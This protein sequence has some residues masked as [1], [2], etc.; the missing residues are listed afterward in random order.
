MKK[1]IILTTY[2]LLLI[3][4]LGK[5]Q[6]AINNSAANPDA[7]AILDLNT[8][9]AG[10][11]KGF[12]APQVALTNVTLAAPVTSPATGLIVY[13]TTA[14]IGGNGTG[15]YY[16]SGSAWLSLGTSPANANLTQGTG[17]T[18]FTYNGTGAATVGIA[19]TGV[20]ANSYG[21]T[22]TYPTFTVNAQGQLT[23]AG[24]QPLPTSLPPNGTAGGDL[25]GTYPNPTVAKINGATVPVAG[26][27]TTGNVLQVNGINSTTYGPVDIAGGA[28]YIT[29]N[30]P[31]TNLN[32]GTNASSTTFW[33]GDGTWANPT[34]ATLSNLTQGTGIT[35]FTYNGSS[36]ATVGLA[37]TGVTAGSYGSATT[38]PTYTVNAQGQITG[39]ANVTISSS[40]GTVT[41]FSSGNLAPLFTTSVATSTTTPALTYTLS[42]AGA[43]TILGNNT[44]AS[45]APTY[46]TP[47][48][49]SA[50]FKNQGA[51]TTVLH[52]N[53]AGNPA[54]GAVDLAT[55][56][57]NNLPVTNLNSGTGASSTTFW[58]GDGT[59]ATP[60]GSS[61]SGSGTNNYLARWTPNG[62]TLGIGL[63]QDNNT[64]VGINSAPVTGN[65]LYVNST[66]GSSIVGY[67]TAAGDA[68]VVGEDNSAGASGVSAISSLGYGVYAEGGKYAGYFVGSTGSAVGV[69]ASGVDTG[70]NAYGN[71]TGIRAYGTGASSAGIYAQGA[72][73]AYFV[74]NGFQGVYATGAYGGLFNGTTSFGARAAGSTEGL[75]AYG[76]SGQGVY[77]SSGNAAADSAVGETYGVYGFTYDP[78]A[79]NAGVYGRDDNDAGV[80]GFS[81]NGVGIFGESGSS[82]GVDGLGL[83]GGYF[84]GVQQGVFSQSTGAAGD[85]SVGETYGV[86]AKAS[87]GTGVAGYGVGYGVEGYGE[88]GVYGSGTAFGV[89]GY[90]SSTLGGS[91]G[92]SGENDNGGCYGVVGSSVNGAGVYGQSAGGGYGISAYGYSGLPIFSYYNGGSNPGSTFESYNVL[93]GRYTDIDEYT[94]STEYK[95]RGGGTVSTIVKNTKGEDVTLH[96]PETPE[97]YFEDYGEGQLVNG[98]VHIDLDP[99]IAKNVIINEKHPLRVFIQLNDT[100][101]KGV[102]VMHK[103]AGGFDVVEINGG[104][105]FTPFEWHIVC[106]RADEVMPSGNVSHTAD[107]RFEKV[108]D[109]S[110]NGAKALMMAEQTA[111]RDSVAKII[112]QEKAAV[113][114]IP[115]A[116]AHQMP[117]P[118]HSQNLGKN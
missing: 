110:A 66:T 13:T 117:P 2:T 48:L 52:G 90:A 67:S 47:T 8:G 84:L 53:A 96:C 15:Y 56:V 118:L 82:I 111:K 91:A 64:G 99:D 45:A 16:W 106:N 80:W 37:N 86:Y 89:D 11:N 6:I 114:A 19:N 61:I 77:S 75:E 92:V 116:N 9:N 30:L 21:N 34:A 108:P 50:L 44:N 87:S 18:S 57:S 42:N 10:V 24:T 40:S 78:T 74:G 95:I 63:I 51:T 79:N 112:A 73:G 5:A 104:K 55:D 68:G 41:N 28:N 26:S 60:S 69:Y 58:R 27:L 33:R 36:T 31:V 1:L 35:T 38:V 7:S 32:S 103:T 72:G 113:P 54:W 65:M 109:H 4:I 39:A 83:Q 85:S 81:A 3:P 62:N 97:I 93:S 105:S 101:C 12:L 76:A 88:F 46:F 43:Y 20:T 22:T 59:W 70:I 14:P 49:A 29:G 107:L 71:Y 102:A 100:G 25:S 98:T 17:I 115:A 23:V 94:G